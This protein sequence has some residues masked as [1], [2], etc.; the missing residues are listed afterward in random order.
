MRNFE[1]NFLGKYYYYYYVEKIN[2]VAPTKQIINL[3]SPYSKVT[4]RTHKFV[5]FCTIWYHW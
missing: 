4:K 1:I 3:V 2:M 5:V